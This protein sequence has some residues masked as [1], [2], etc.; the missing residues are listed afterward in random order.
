MSR[1]NS[2]QQSLEMPVPK[3]PSTVLGNHIQQARPRTSLSTGGLSSTPNLN[4]EN[5]MYDQ[6]QYTYSDQRHVHMHAAEPDPQLARRVDDIA[7]V[8]QQHHIDRER[9]AQQVSDMANISQQAFSQQ[10]AEARELAARQTQLERHVQ[11]YINDC[12]QTIDGRVQTLA[13]V[14]ESNRL[15][16][17]QVG[18]RHREDCRALANRFDEEIQR[19]T[20]QSQPTPSQELVSFPTPVEQQKLREERDN[21]IIESIR[22]WACL[23]YTSPSPRDRS[24]SRM[25][26]SA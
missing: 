5:Q 24:L 22:S 4:V 6:R 25:P 12:L 2:H 21:Q 13:T 26:S 23:L 1:M 20:T 17:S 15:G 3:A 11:Q 10:E 8:V 9:A 16:V 14:V 18:S 19:I 7:H